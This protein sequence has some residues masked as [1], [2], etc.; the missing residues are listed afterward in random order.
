M[1]CPSDLAKGDLMIE[2]EL[3]RTRG[4]RRRYLLEDVGTL[5]LEGLFSRSATAE[6]GNEYWHLAHRGFWQRIMQATDARGTVVGE[7]LPRDLRRG[8]KLYWA[9]RELTLRPAS[10]WR[11]RYALAEGERELVLIDGKSWGRRPVK[12]T[13]PDPGAIEP[14]LI[15]FT[16][17]I[18]RQLAVN[19]DSAS[20]AATTVASTG[21]YSG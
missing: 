20:S 17:F 11:E 3:A 14:G 5:R 16:A 7:F 15:L 19:A 12:V 21:S 10:S 13:L 18:V 2:L 1:S 4:D 8:G 6:A 9:D